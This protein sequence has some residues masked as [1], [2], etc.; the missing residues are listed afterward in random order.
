MANRISLAC[1]TIRVV[2]KR[3]RDFKLLGQISSSHDLITVFIEYLNNLREVYAVYDEQQI[4]RHI[5]HY[6]K[7]GWTVN[8]IIETG[9]YGFST[10]LL[11]VNDKS[12]SYERDRNDAEMMPFYFLAY[13]PSTHDEGI[14]LLQRRSN[15]GVRTVF[16]NDFKY[17]VEQSY[18]DTSIDINNL[19]PRQLIENYLRDGRLTSMRLI[20]FKLPSDVVDALDTD[21]HTEIGGRMELNLIVNRGKSLPFGNKI[22][23]VLDG[24][25]EM[26]N[27]VEISDFEYENV[28]VLIDVNGSKKTLDLSDTGKINSYLDVTKEV[29]MNNDGFPRFESIDKIAQS[30]LDGLLDLMGL[31]RENVG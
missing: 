5:L 24:D 14:I 22:L 25:L 13:L 3:T 15:I 2:D 1:Y 8:G 21:G 23:R 4:M 27:L 26:T 12:V 7:N 29:E 18:P 11:N 31:S 6:N 9:E 17:Y 30:H 10:N 19:V 20:Q 16:F 28:K